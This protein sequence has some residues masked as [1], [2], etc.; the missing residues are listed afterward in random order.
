[1]NVFEDLNFDIVE[2][3]ISALQDLKKEYPRTQESKERLCM[4]TDAGKLV[5]LV[6]ED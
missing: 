5:H 6:M 1:M 4:G 3:K 2:E